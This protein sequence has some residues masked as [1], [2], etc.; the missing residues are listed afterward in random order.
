MCSLRRMS[1]LWLVSG[2]I[3]DLGLKVDKQKM[4][5]GKWKNGVGDRTKMK[6]TKTLA[7][8]SSAVDVKL[9]NTALGEYGVLF[10]N[11]RCLVV[12]LAERTCSCKWWQLKGLQT[13]HAMAIIDKQSYGCMIML[14][15]V[16]R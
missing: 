5:L 9:L 10:M 7:N 12:N 2:H 13:A 11:N 3:Q 15:I 16:I 1:I 4:E 6:L 14:A 8:I